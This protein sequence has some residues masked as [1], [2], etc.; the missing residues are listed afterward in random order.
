MRDPYGRGHIENVEW[1]TVAVYTIF[2][3]DR[4]VFCPYNIFTLTMLCCRVPPPDSF[5][6]MQKGV[7]SGDLTRPRYS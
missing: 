5:H 1:T 7:R 6:L 4:T 3:L 2:H